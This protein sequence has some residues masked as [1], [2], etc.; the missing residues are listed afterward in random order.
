M[1]KFSNSSI[2][3]NSR[4]SKQTSNYTHTQK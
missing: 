2:F 4:V 3:K 1:N